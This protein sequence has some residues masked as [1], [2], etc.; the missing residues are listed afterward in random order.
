[1]EHIIIPQV[2]INKKVKIIRISWEKRTP[3][4]QFRIIRYPSDNPT[5]TY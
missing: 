5:E 3:R 4:D 2:H 1:M